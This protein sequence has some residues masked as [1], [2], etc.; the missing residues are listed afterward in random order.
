MDQVKVVEIRRIR[1]PSSLRAFV[2]VW[3][4]NMTVADFRVFQEN[5]GPAR[6]EAHEHM[7][8]SGNPPDSI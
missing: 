2:D 8:R 4:G 7:A 3:M 6:V 1:K 5:G